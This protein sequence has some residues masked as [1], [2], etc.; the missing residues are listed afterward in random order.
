MLEVLGRGGVAQVPI[1]LVEVVASDPGGRKVVPSHA[2]SMAQ[3]SC[4]LATI[5]FMT[6]GLPSLDLLVEEMR[7][8]RQDQ[9][10]HF[11]AL[12]SKAGVLLGFSGAI[13]AL[14]A[15]V[16]GAIS[17]LA[18]FL[19]SLAA[20]ASVWAFFAEEVSEVP[21]DR[22]KESVS[23]LRSRVHQ[24]KDSGYSDRDDHADCHSFARQGCKA[25]VDLLLVG[26]DSGYPCH[27]SDPEY[28]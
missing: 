6:K 14:R 20:L 10:Q 24:A 23:D 13:V 2:P 28:S 26:G 16:P 3:L 22:T 25:Q 1:A 18:T 5:A 21:G 9:I 4:L 27:T 15:G 7:I 8:I 19:A 17:L 12:E 11:D